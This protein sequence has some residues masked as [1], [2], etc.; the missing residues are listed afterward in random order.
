[1]A[2][3]LNRPVSQLFVP[4]NRRI[5]RPEVPRNPAAGCLNAEVSNHWS[6][7]LIN[8]GVPT[9]SARFVP[10]V[11]FNPP[12]SAAEM[13]IGNPRWKVVIAFTCQPP[14]TRLAALGILLRNFL[15]RPTGN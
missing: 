13:V 4:G 1:M 8:L 2:K 10:E 12:T 14:I 15:P 7:D 9:K 11:S 6:M 5:P 3:F